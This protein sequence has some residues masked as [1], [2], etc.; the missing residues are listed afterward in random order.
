MLT[1]EELA[2]NSYLVMLRKEIEEQYMEHPTGCGGSFGELL[3]Y[4]IHSGMTFVWL[5]EKWG[6]PL[7]TLGELIHDHCKRLEKAPNINHDYRIDK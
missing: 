5:A 6:I 1:D 2:N 3:C 4:E 7:T